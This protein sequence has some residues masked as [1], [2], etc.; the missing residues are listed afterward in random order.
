L[1]LGRSYGV[2]DRQGR[3]RG[4]HADGVATAARSDHAAEARRR[5]VD[6]DRAPG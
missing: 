4:S 2:A 1:K 5:R 3:R 6:R